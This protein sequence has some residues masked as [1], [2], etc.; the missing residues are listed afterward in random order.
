MI[1]RGICHCVGVLV[2]VSHHVLKSRRELTVHVVTTTT[3]CQGPAD[4]GRDWQGEQATHC[5]LDF[6]FVVRC[7]LDELMQL[8]DPLE[9][10]QPDIRWPCD[11]RRGTHL[12]LL[13]YV[14]VPN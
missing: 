14:Y 11:F 10:C 3:R 4:K 13:P 8:V 9:H 7:S 12:F 2:D 5:R 6:G 1:S